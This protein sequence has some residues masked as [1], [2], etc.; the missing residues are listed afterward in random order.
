M[1]KILSVL[2]AVF[3]FQTLFSGEFNDKGAVSGWSFAPVQFDVGLVNSKKLVDESSDTFFSFGVFMLQ[4]KS[5][6]LSVALVANTLQ[7]NYGIQVN[8]FPIGVGTDVNYGI[9][10]GFE[11]Y[12]KKCYGIQLGLLNHS[13][14]GRQIAKECEAVQVLGMNIADTVYIGAVNISDKVQLGVLNM[15]PGAA[16]QIG[17]LNY[18]LKSYIPWMPL[19]NF[20]MG[21]PAKTQH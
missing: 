5:A 13:W 11:N 10:L 17:L 3:I 1:K 8:P 18:N 21:R 15:S 14:A 20:D 16:F 4:Q 19:I 2:L 7:N 12:S 6:V 9:S